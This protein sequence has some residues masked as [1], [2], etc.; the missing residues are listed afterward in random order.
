MPAA[1]VVDKGDQLG[2]VLQ[3]LLERREAERL[4]VESWEPALDGQLYFAA[5]DVV[6][7]TLSQLAHDL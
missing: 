4:L 6:L 1:L 7:L 2:E 5:E 3:E